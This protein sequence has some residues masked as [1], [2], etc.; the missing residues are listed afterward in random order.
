[1]TILASFA[2]PHPP[3]ILPEVGRGEERKI[4]A[5]TAAYEA[6]MK[7]AAEFQPDTLI[8][9]SPHAE[10]YLDYF[11]IAPGREAQ[12]NFAQF[13]A[14][15][16]K[17]SVQYDRD[18]AALI[19][20]EAEKSGI[21]AGLEGERNPDLGHGTLIPLYFY[22]KFGSLEKVRIVRIGLSGMSPAI[23]YR[24]G[25]CIRDAAEKLGCRAVFIASGDL[26]HKLKEDG[27]YGYVPEGPIFDRQCTE[28]LGQ[29]DFFRLLTLDHSLCT[30]AAECGLR[31]FWIMAGAW[32][33][34]AVRSRLLSYEGPFGVGYGVASFLG[35]GPDPSRKFLRPLLETERKQRAERIAQEDPYVKLARLAVET[36]IKNHE[37]APLPADLPSE[38]LHTRAGAFVSLHL[39]DQLRG[40]IGTFLPTQDC[41]AREILLNGIAAA[42]RD[43]R[44]PA[45]RLEELP[46]LEY[47]VDVLST[48]E[49]ISGPEE[50]DPRKYGIIVKSA[51]DERRGLLLPDLDGVDTVD[52]QISIARQKGNIAAKEPVNL[53][54]FQVV[55]HR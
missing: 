35:E 25:Q 30:R 41:L 5:T 13:G 28:A 8:I 36:Y 50:L 20:D 11:H 45:V 1:M 17:I 21:P 46:Y 47:N 44:F 37:I 33:G 23:H 4:A 26:S 49:P 53:F 42:T 14:S 38:M 22:R 43:P 27:P 2:V 16:V 15:Q 19:A 34:T 32:D 12:G 48:P 7:Q 51:Q 18:L 54:R 6:A 9:T 31:S 3:I 29:G 40:C 39:Q 55:R 10:M 24:F 52:A